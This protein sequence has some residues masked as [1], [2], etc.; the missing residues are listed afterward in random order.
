MREA[1]QLIVEAIELAGVKADYSP[2][3]EYLPSL[4]IGDEDRNLSPKERVDR[5]VEMYWGE[6]KKRREKEE[7]P[8]L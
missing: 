6:E 3:G 7:E 4:S 1:A 8:E 5:I 2:D